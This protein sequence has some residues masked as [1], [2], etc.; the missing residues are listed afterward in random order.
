[1]V[2]I[3]LTKWHK[4]AGSDTTSSTLTYILYELARSSDIQKQLYDELTKKATELKLP[5][6]DIPHEELGN[7]K[8][9]NA[10]VKEGLRI[11]P[12]APSSLPRYVPEGGRTIAN[13]QF[14]EKV[15][16][17]YKHLKKS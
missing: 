17:T 13:F 7:L 15:T 3:N 4:F 8:F 12:A 16:H 6:Y 11:H 2:Y 9:L 14:P 1:M 10:V 5:I